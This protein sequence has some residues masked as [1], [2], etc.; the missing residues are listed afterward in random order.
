MHRPGRS[1]SCCTAF[2]TA[3]LLAPQS[4]HLVFRGFSAQSPVSGLAGVAQQRAK[5][6]QSQL[7]M[8]LTDRAQQ[9]PE[10][11]TL[12]DSGSIPSKA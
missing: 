5:G 7:I 8:F 11:D 1:S 12:R 2:S 4:T 6:M 3:E 10:R 9:L